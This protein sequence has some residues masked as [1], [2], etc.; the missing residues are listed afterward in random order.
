MPDEPTRHD[1]AEDRTILANERTFASW[2]RTSLGCIAIGLGFHGLFAPMAPGWAPR[3]MATLFLL[4][5]IWVMA[6]AER[7]TSA[8]LKRLDSHA[9]KTAK[10]VNLRLLTGLVCLGS[11]GLICAIW[12]MRM[13][14][15]N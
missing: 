3:L 15:G 8:L 5:A 1:L 12:L 10:A 11:A 9:V 13:P 14:Q 6:M 7:R 2:M 4:L